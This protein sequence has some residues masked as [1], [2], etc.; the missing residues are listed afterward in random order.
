MRWDKK[1]N[2]IEIKI[3]D[4]T[5]KNYF[6]KNKNTNKEQSIHDERK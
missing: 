2:Q 4:N 1:K 6:D 5:N 3:V